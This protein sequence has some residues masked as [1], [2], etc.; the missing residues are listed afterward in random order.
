M[1]LQAG[2]SACERP[3]S[4]LSSCWTD[5]TRLPRSKLTWKVSFCFSDSR[6]ACA[7]D[8]DH[9]DLLHTTTGDNRPI[10]SMAQLRLKRDCIKAQWVVRQRDN[11]QELL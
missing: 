10:G 11:A 7:E 2:S 3:L 8:H 6:A 4:R 5:G 1:Y 9:H